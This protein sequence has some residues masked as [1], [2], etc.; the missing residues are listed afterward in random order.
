MKN[1]AILIRIENKLDAM[2]STMTARTNNA[3]LSERLSDADVRFSS[4]LAMLSTIQGSFLNSSEIT[5]YSLEGVRN[6]LKAAY[7][8]LADGTIYDGNLNDF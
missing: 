8:V 4:A 2:A 7:Q 5:Y 1:E 6:E 3:E